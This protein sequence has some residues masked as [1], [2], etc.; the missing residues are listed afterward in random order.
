M[1]AVKAERAR[2][3]LKKFDWEK[4]VRKS[5]LGSVIRIEGLPDDA[6]AIFLFQVDDVDYYLLKMKP[7]IVPN[8]YR[9]VPVRQIRAVV[10]EPKELIFATYT[11]WQ[12]AH[13]YR[14]NY[15]CGTCGSR[16][17]LSKTERALVCPECGRLIY[18][19]IV[20][21]VIPDRQA[22][23]RQMLPGRA[24]P[25]L[26]RRKHLLPRRPDGGEQQQGG[27]YLAEGQGAKG[28]SLS[29]Q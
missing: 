27:Q 3:I 20:P 11:A 19:R 28:Q 6:D 26:R 14:D 21:A 13:W 15:F 9:F 8:G 12:L 24:G 17:V 22:E 25:D 10:T 4:R 29:I 16:T 23:R 7:I 2:T 18:P 5:P 1:T